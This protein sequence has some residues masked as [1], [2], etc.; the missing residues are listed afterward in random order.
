MKGGRLNKGLL[1]PLSVPARPW[2]DISMDFITGLPV[3]GDG[4]DAILRFVDRLM[5]CVHLI[6]IKSTID[7][8]ATVTVYIRSVFRLHGLSRSIV[9]DR[10]PRFTATFFSEVFKL[11]GNSL[12]MSTANHPQ[13]MV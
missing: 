11:L 6:P 1:Q 10:D 13:T 12:Q 9:C 7:A 8:E 2:Q 5:K 3:S 4:Y